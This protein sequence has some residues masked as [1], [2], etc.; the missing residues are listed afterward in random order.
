MEWGEIPPDGA[1]D[2][3]TKRGGAKEKEHLT[4]KGEGEI[5]PLSDVREFFPRG[6]TGKKMQTSERIVK[7]LKEGS[8]ILP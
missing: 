1:W 4:E 8:T 2:S 5:A 7:G 6:W 3:H